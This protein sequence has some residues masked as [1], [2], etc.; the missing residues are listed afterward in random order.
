MHS[1]VGANGSKKKNKIH[2]AAVL[3][4]VGYS[5]NDV[6]L[7]YHQKLKAMQSNGGM[8]EDPSGISL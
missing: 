4:H 5:Q 3:S 1:R 6:C 7:I 2:S 8:D